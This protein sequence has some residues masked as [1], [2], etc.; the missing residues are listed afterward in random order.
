M[1]TPG[2]LAGYIGQYGYAALALYSLENLNFGANGTVKWKPD[3]PMK[4]AMKDFELFGNFIKGR[5]DVNLDF[6]ED[7][8]LNEYNLEI[9]ET[10]IE[11]LI[12][13]VPDSVLRSFGLERGRLSTECAVNLK[14]KS[15]APFNL[16][17]DTI[18]NTD[19]ELAISPGAFSYDKIKFKNISGVLAASLKGNDLDQAVFEGR[20][21]SIVGP[22]T[23]LLINVVATQVSGDPL[24][25]AA[26]AAKPI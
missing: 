25:K 11:E 9:A 5:M 8:V 15:T 20:D 17:V 10:R 19:I 23:D 12:S 26:I 6:T 7:I 24:I 22:A 14:V 1:W 18:P 3:E 2:I 16:S 4:L 21:L 13:L